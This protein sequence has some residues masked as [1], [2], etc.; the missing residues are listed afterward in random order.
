MGPLLCLHRRT[1]GSRTN[2]ALWLCQLCKT[3]NAYNSQ[4]MYENLL[5]GFEVFTMNSRELYS[6][7]FILSI[8]DF[9]EDNSEYFPNFDERTLRLNGRTMMSQTHVQK[10]EDLAF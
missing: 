4:E 8:A 7:S 3:G 6:R 5:A 2:L 1:A 10:S 9:N